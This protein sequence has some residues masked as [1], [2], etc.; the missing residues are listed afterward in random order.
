MV[1]RERIDPSD[2]TSPTLADPGRETAWAPHATPLLAPDDIKQIDR[3]TVLRKLGEGGMGVVFAARDPALN[4]VVALKLVGSRVAGSED[5]QVR[6]MREAQALAR[7]SH[8]NVVQV[9]DVG[10]HRGSVYVAMEYID[11]V[12][13]G[14]W[15]HEHPPRDRSSRRALIKMYIQAGR[16]LAAA[17]E[18]GLVHRDFKP[19]NVLIEGATGTAHVVDFGLACA[20][21]ERADETL[22]GRGLSPPSADGDLLDTP[23]TRAGIVLGTP[24]YMAPEQ[25]DGAPADA[26]SDQYSFCCCLLEALVGERP[27][28]RKSGRPPQASGRKIPS[29]LRRA[30]TRG[31]EYNPEHRWPG[32]PALLAELEREVAPRRAPLWAAT[33]LALLGG[34]YALVGR[35]LAEEDRA[36]A[37]DHARARWSG[38]WDDA[39]AQSIAAAFAGLAV[40]YADDTWQTVAT[41]IDRRVDRWVAAHVDACEQH[42][43]GAQS[44]QTLDRRMSC[45]AQR[46]VETAKVIDILAAPSSE[47]A[48]RAIDAVAT[49]RPLE[50]CSDPL[51]LRSEVAMPARASARARVTALREQ[52]AAEIGRL[53]R[54]AAI[55]AEL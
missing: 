49:L 48:L 51:A 9:H 22:P 45:L 25:R 52:V 21:G 12:T 40:P 29:R 11:G 15:Q 28:E 33:A 44:G 37:E 17:H 53:Q 10:S 23:L 13:L 1:S 7:L 34:S 5:L 3:F 18:C 54:T 4:R 2:D 8:P 38:V 39:R 20:R 27:S 31:L 46:Q 26:R 19:A 32:M 6:M 43:R 24:S 50:P 41:R 14:E 47:T 16:G 30:L 36:C 42:L 35:G 55:V